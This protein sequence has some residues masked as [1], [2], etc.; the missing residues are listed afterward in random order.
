MFFN[1]L[2]RGHFL[3]EYISRCHFSNDF[4]LKFGRV[5]QQGRG[6]SSMQNL[7]ILSL[8][9]SRPSTP[10]GCGEFWGF[11]PA[12]GPLS[13]G[14]SST[15]APWEQV[16]LTGCLKER[17]FSYQ[18][19]TVSLKTWMPHFLANLQ[20]GHPKVVSHGGVWNCHG[21]NLKYHGGNMDY[22][23][24]VSSLPTQGW[25]SGGW[26]VHGDMSWDTCGVQTLILS[27]LAG[28]GIPF[29]RCIFLGTY[30]TTHYCISDWVNTS[31]N[32][33]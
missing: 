6:L 23:D 16:T 10:A 31:F 5:R 4:G 12:V 20:G 3:L 27:I 26:V 19:T 14:S 32:V 30:F 1:V 25:L 21:G 17:C 7:N 24:G 15:A 29:A 33:N 9:L 13:A 2:L 11:A 8:P 22:H 28:F 18:G